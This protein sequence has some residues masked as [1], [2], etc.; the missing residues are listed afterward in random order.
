MKKK[1]ATLASGCL[2][3]LNITIDSISKIWMSTKNVFNNTAIY[4][5]GKG[6]QIVEW[7]VETGEILKFV[8]SYKSSVSTINSLVQKSTNKE[9]FD[10]LTLGIDSLKRNL[11]S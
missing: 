7:S 1:A 8:S 3:F 11:K 4:S 9:C 2:L 6:M 5:V 10:I